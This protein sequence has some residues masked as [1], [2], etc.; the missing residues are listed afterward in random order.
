MVGLESGV[1]PSVFI[2]I[3]H[4]TIL[5]LQQTAL[6]GTTLS[7]QGCTHMPKRSGKRETGAGPLV[8]ARFTTDVFARGKLQGEHGITPACSEW[9]QRRMPCRDSS[10]GCVCDIMQDTTCA[11]QPKYRLQFHRC[12]RYGICGVGKLDTLPILQESC[13]VIIL[14]LL[15]TPASIKSCDTPPLSNCKI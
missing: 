6:Y 4:S 10:A 3:L 2:R 7:V 1:M 5:C 12:V 15:R 11:N 8:S 9:L 14:R 13:L